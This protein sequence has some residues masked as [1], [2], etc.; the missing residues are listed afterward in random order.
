MAIN[1]SDKTQY[2]TV[3][4][5]NWLGLG[6]KLWHLSKLYSLGRSLSYSYIHTPFRCP[7]SA[8]NS[9]LK[10]NLTS[11]AQPLSL[12]IGEA[13]YIGTFLGLDKRE[14]TISDPAFRDIEVVPVNLDY[15]FENNHFSNLKELSKS[16]ENI[17]SKS[18]NCVKLLTTQTGIYSYENSINTLIGGCQAESIY[19][20]ELGIAREYWRLRNKEPISTCFRPDKVKILIHIRNGDT[21]TFKFGNKIISV[22]GSSAQILASEDDIKEAKRKPVN[23]KE[24]VE[25]IEN[26]YQNSSQKPSIVFIS[27]GYGR[28]AEV[29]L[30]CLIKREI[31]LGYLDSLK[32]LKKTFDL[33]AE[34]KSYL[35][36]YKIVSIIGESQGKLM[37]S[38]HSIAEA[39]IVIMSTGGFAY[40]IYRFLNKNS[41]QIVDVNTLL[42]KSADEFRNIFLKSVHKVSNKKG[43]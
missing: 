43:C 32:L 14:K 23:F 6:D 33:N 15:I 4:L 34:L 36:F 30:K 22:F 12:G 13:D 20:E 7:R 19:V 11:I 42:G 16:I 26:V 10:L 35:E 5:P 39:D 2:F 3:D 25:L 8:S 31:K 24:L 29:I 38:I 41:S 27:D 17:D 21:T 28:A 9:Y 1:P 18:M 37:A 40:S